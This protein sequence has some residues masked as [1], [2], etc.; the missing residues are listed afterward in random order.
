MN[1]G[2]VQLRRGIIDHLADGRLTMAEFS[3]FNLLLLLASSDSGMGKINAAYLRAFFGNLSA[4]ASK[5]VLHSLEEKGYIFRNITPRSPLLYP[6]WVNGYIVTFG[7]RLGS[8]LNIGKALISKDVADIQYLPCAPE[9]APWS[10]PESAHYYKNREQR[11]KQPVVDST[12][13]QME[14]KRLPPDE[15]MLEAV[16]E[17]LDH[18]YEVTGEDRN[19]SHPK[20]E[21]MARARLRDALKMRDGN[22]DEGVELM[23]GAIDTVDRWAKRT[24]RGP[25]NFKGIFATTGSFEKWAEDTNVQLE[26][27]LPP[28]P[29]E[30]QEEIEAKDLQTAVWRAMRLFPDQPG[31]EWFCESIRIRQE[32]DGYVKKMPFKDAMGLLN[33]LKTEADVLAIVGNTN[34]S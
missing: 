19:S 11:T 33:G 20:Y 8:R 27:R 13:I 34:N 16:Q 30:T 26:R 5:R 22:L 23:T 32:L 10:A 24:G 7:S 4:D 1:S 9:S 15:E 18:F 3:V 21:A 31:T 28:P 17:V 14:E 2:Y 29:P 6:Y 12:I 25:V